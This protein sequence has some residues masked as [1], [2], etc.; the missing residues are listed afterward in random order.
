MLRLMQPIELPEGTSV[1]IIVI[2]KTSDSQHKSHADILA[3]IA[4]LPLED[5]ADKFSG[6]EHD[7]VLLCQMPNV[8]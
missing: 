4:A 5:N 1:E 7:K 6:R 3:E 2:P 8:S